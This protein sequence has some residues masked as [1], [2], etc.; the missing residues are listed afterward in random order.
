M[1]W[2]HQKNIPPRYL[3]LD[4]RPE[5]ARFPRRNSQ[6][7]HPDQTRVNAGLGEGDTSTSGLTVSLLLAAAGTIR[8]DAFTRV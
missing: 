7:R 6:E 8:S 5:T 3:P 4:S 2:S 1:L